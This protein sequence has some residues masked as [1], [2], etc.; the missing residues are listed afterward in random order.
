MTPLAITSEKHRMAV[1]R[2]SR[3]SMLECRVEGLAVV[4]AQ[5]PVHQQ[6]DPGR[7][8]H[9]EVAEQPLREM[10]LVCL[11]SSTGSSR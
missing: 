5:L 4:A 7:G 3:W 6:G 11:E 1:G 9:V 10:N 8:Q 2:S